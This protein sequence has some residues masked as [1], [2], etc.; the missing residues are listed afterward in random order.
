M[1][2]AM[3]IVTRMTGTSRETVPKDV[4]RQSQIKFHYLDKLRKDAHI[5]GER[6]LTRSEFAAFAETTKT[7]SQKM[8]VAEASRC[9]NCGTCI[10]CDRCLNF[11]PDYAITKNVD[12]KYSI[13]L[14]YCKGCGLC[15][16]VC[17]RAA[18]LYGKEGGSHD[19][20]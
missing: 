16:D 15:A 9:I 13:D 20:E 7:I 3:Q 5:R 17:E 8:A 14:D 19:Q 2:A 6:K 4:V 11:C 12:G 1:L 18:V 10:A